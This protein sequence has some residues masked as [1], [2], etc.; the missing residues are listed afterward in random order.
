MIIDLLF[1]EL[2]F[3]TPVA[4][5][6]MALAVFKIG[7]RGRLPIVPPFA[8]DAMRL[9][10]F[11]R[12]LRTGLAVRVQVL[13]HAIEGLAFEIKAFILPLEF[14]IRRRRFLFFARR[15]E[16]C[17]EDQSDGKKRSDHRTRAVWQ[18]SPSA[19][20]VDVVRWADCGSFKRESPASSAA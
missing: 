3:T 7:L 12:I 19:A 20:S 13:G 11:H 16:E 2:A 6:P 15:D 10:V 1:E 17:G 18:E 4:I 9:A 14:A 5:A 8:D